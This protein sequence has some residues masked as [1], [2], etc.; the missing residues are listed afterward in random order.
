MPRGSV[1]G[2]MVILLK[3]ILWFKSMS[4]A[5][6]QDLCSFYQEGVVSSSVT[7]C[8]AVVYL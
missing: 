3:L 2:K 4:Y 6:W 8:I 7:E 5:S 1:L